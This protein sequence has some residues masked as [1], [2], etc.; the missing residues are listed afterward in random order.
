[1]KEVD[2]STSVDD[3]ETSQSIRG[4]RLPNFEMLDEEDHPKFELQEKSQSG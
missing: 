3:L 4:H 1:M 2:V